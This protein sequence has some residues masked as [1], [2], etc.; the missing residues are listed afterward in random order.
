MKFYAEE[1]IDEMILRVIQTYVKRNNSH[2]F[3]FFFSNR[4]LPELRSI[5]LDIT[6]KLEGRTAGRQL[7]EGTK[8][9]PFNLTVPKART[10]SVPKTVRIKQHY[11]FHLIRIFRYQK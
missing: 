9:K 1:Y 10:F 5:L 6:N 4:H 2:V 7:P 11:R 3:I 8:T